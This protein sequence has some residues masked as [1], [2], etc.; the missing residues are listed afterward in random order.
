MA[1]LYII[2]GHGG[3]DPGACAG[4]YSE[5]DL[6]RKL[7]KRMDA[8]G[9]SNVTVL[10]TSKNW[11]ATGGISSLNIPKDALLI[12][13]HLDSAVASARG[14]HVIIK[15]GFTA[16][17]YDKAIAAFLGGY[18][19]GRSN[20]IVGRSDLANVNR[21]AARGINYR[22]VEVCFISNSTDRNKLIKN[23]DDV[24]RGLLKACGVTPKSSSTTASTGTKSYLVHVTANVLNVRKGAGTKYAIA[25]T[26][27]KGEVYTIVE[28]KLVNGKKWGKLKSGAGWIHLGYTKTV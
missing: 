12:E 25:T 4:G 15:S 11:Y 2:A 8:L 7:A 3:G 6:V 17:K 26:V 27:R 18:F 9:G 19:P 24:A 21:A 1:K 23:M 13:L 20:M 14:G 5:A 28:T 10:D 16:D 22:L